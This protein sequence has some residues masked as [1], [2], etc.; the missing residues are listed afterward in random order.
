MSCSSCRTSAWKLRVRA[1]RRAFLA[2]A[3]S[4]MI[5][6]CQGLIVIGVPIRVI[7]QI[8]SIAEL[9]TEIQPSVQSRDE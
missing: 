1:L 6:D 2:D 7:I 4:V 3:C 5:R 9:L 8:S